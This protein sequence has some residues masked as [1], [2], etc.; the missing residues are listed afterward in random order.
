MAVAPRIS[1]SVL[2]SRS[3]RGIS[4]PRPSCISVYPPKFF[5]PMAS[6]NVARAPGISETFSCLKEQGKVSSRDSTPPLISFLFRSVVLFLFL[7]YWLVVPDVPLE[8]TESLT[9]EAVKHKIELATT[10]P[11]AVGFGISK[12]EH[13]KQVAGWG[14]DGVIVGSAMVK[15]LGEAKSPEEGLKELEAFTRS[16]KAALP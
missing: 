14:A 7:I 9:K 11:V 12:P 8:E 5:S 16:L 2:P 1:L 15:L 10:K 13:V 6:L 3:S 4:L